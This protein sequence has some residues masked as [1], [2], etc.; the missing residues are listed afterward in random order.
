MCG[1]L[2]CF[3][4]I[5]EAGMELRLNEGLAAIQHR[6]PDDQGLDRFDIN[7]SVLYL[8]QA[9]LS[10]IDLSTAGH[11]PMNSLDGRYTIVFNG[12]I[13]NYRELRD[14][15]KIL[16]YEFNTQTDTEV[17]LVAWSAW[18]KAAIKRFT[19]MFAFAIYDQQT[20]QMDIVRDAFGIKPLYYFFDKASFYF[21]SEPRSLTTMLGKVPEINLQRASDYLAY[22]LYDHNEE[23]FFKG[24]Y[25][26]LPAHHLTIDLKKFQFAKPVRWWWPEIKE[27]KDLSFEAASTHLKNLFIDNIRLHMRSD[28]P[29]GAALSGGLDSSSV[30]AAMR[31]IAPNSELHS[32]TYVA[33]NS[34]K[35]EEDWANKVIADTAAKSHKIYVEPRELIEDLD[36]MI[37]ILG[38][39]FGST[40]IYAQYRVFKAAKE[41]GIIVTLDGQGAD[42]LLAGYHGYPV[43][44]MQSM[45][46]KGHV[47][48]AF[49]FIYNWTKWPGRNGRMALAIVRAAITPDWV[50]KAID[51][52]LK[53]TS[54]P[55][56]LHKKQLLDAGVRITPPRAIF[57]KDTGKKRR[58]VEQLRSA[59]LGGGLSQLLRHGDRTSMRWSIESRVP[60]LTTELAEFVLSLPEEY[61]VSKDG[62]TKSIFREAM[63]GIVPDEILDRKDK[64]G[65][66][67]PEYIWLCDHINV[68]KEWI[69]SSPNL[70]FIDRDTAIEEVEAM[71]SGKILYDRRAWR[72]INFYR[73]ASLTYG[74]NYQ[75]SL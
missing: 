60:F 42:E 21:A 62:Q 27:R 4:Q 17:L 70:P 41:A 13:Y 28:V 34:D 22:G 37:T 52:V 7:D 43:S 33:L 67:T 18:G 11:Q 14:E 39:P 25:H 50:K 16:G 15:L 5:E 74:D 49:R 46:E 23:T 8:G 66:E 59:L 26:L 20:S 44:V 47:I 38:E 3:N 24:I 54:L 73:W 55:I 9:R 19:G 65:F 63:R 51:L 53:R 69:L 2:G 45:I 1:I 71:L 75:A 35:N 29:L 56:W 64:I 31:A 57:K 10:I 30:V 58:L 12:E 6:G 40:S 61:L 32:F 48:A 72:I 68:I 36:D